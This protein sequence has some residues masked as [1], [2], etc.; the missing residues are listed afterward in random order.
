MDSVT[1]S[2]ERE[3]GEDSHHQLFSDDDIDTD[4]EKMMEKK[5]EKRRKNIKRNRNSQTRVTRK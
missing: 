4:S 1:D 3:G 2:V 5:T